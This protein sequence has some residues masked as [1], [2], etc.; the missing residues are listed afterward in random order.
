VKGSKI[1]RK[2]NKID[3]EKINKDEGLV[4]ELKS[5]ARRSLGDY[6]FQKESR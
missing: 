6:R 2:L 4:L 1:G 5:G 3:P